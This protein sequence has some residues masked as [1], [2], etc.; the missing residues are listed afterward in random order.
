MKDSLKLEIEGL[1]VEVDYEYE[2]GR[3]G[4]NTTPPSP[5]FI[6]TKGW[7]LVNYSRKDFCGSDDEWCDWMADIDWYVATDC[8]DDI[9]AH[10]ILTTEYYQ[11][12]YGIS[13]RK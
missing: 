11:K 12:P 10:I 4:D 5:W 6:E 7:R 3:D 1:K 2:E 9:A 8:Y 13:Y